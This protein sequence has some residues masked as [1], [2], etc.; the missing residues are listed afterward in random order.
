MN[1][2]KTNEILKEILKWQKLQGMKILRELIPLL[3]DT[4]EKKKVYELTDG[5]N[6]A[7]E[8]NK[9][10]GVALGTISGWWQEW[11]VNG[12]LV[13]EDGKYEKIISLKELGLSF[14]DA[15]K[16]AKE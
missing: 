7:R 3:I 15:A 9:K 2:D 6:T 13:K 10:T 11:H 14:K 12:I 1:N 5:K 8:I 16:K 4:D